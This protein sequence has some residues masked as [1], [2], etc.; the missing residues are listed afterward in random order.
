MIKIIAILLLF[1]PQLIGAV[2]TQESTGLL[3]KL[4]NYGDHGD[5]WA[6]CIRDSFVIIN[7]AAVSTN[8][9]IGYVSTTTFA[10]EVSSRTTGDI[11]LGVSTGS[12][13]SALNSTAASLTSEIARA[14]ARENAIGVSTGNIQTDLATEVSS[15]MLVGIATGTIYSALNSTGAAITAE[16][17][18]RISAINALGITTGTIN[19]D[20]QSYKTTVQT[21]TAS[22]Y[23]ALQSTGASLTSEIARAIAAEN[24]HSV[25]TST[26]GAVA[27]ATAARIVLR[28]ATGSFAMDTASGTA[29]YLSKAVGTNATFASNSRT[30][31]INGSLLDGANDIYLNYNSG[32][33]VSIG[34]S[35]DASKLLVGD[36]LLS[37]YPHKLTV[38]GGGKFTSSVTADAGFY[39]VLY[40][41]ATS[42]SYF[43]HTPAACGAGQYATAQSSA[44]VLTCGAPAGAGDVLLAAT[45]TFTG[46]NTFQSTV[47]LPTRDKIIF[48]NELANSS[49]TVV[50]AYLITSVKWIDACMPGSTVTITMNGGRAKVEFWGTILNAG[51][52][53][54]TYLNFR[55]DGVNYYT[56]GSP[57][58][59]QTTAGWFNQISFS[60]ITFLI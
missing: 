27:T 35:G 5:V 16:T 21:S 15:R 13:Y 52:G 17:A 30:L 9:I 60:E 54:Q 59:I 24:T 58:I 37:A 11:A 36:D 43:D 45:Q 31:T 12:I 50:P 51:A 6:K 55:R 33:G 19:S 25:A 26:H 40:G 10:Q 34:N 28:D 32:G 20:L 46:A 56:T 39:G 8:T 3:L 47:T 22:I 38:L 18:A 23:S 53:S 7:G 4:P 44:G 49:A 29:V 14:T 42:A 2:C 41:T 48:G 1:Y 57:G